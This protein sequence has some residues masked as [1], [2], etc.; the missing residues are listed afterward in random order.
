[1]VSFEALG[2]DLIKGDDECSSKHQ[3]LNQSLSAIS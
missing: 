1:M 2:I 3:N